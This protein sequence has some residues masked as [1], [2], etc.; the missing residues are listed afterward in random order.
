MRE[1]EE[2]M[3]SVQNRHDKAEYRIVYALEGIAEILVDIR[4][5]LPSPTPKVEVKK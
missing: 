3:K 2:I 1:K 5:L 4:D